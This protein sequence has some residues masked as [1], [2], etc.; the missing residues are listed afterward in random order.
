MSV[1]DPRADALTRLVAICRMAGDPRT[2][3][4]ERAAA[5]ARADRMVERWNFTA[6]EFEGEVRRQDA[7]SKPSRR[8]QRMA[9]QPPFNAHRGVVFTFTFGSSAFVQAT[10]EAAESAFFATKAAGGNYP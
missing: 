3:E 1:E 9:Q 8:A 10:E 6:E 2:P 5:R 4:N 7:A